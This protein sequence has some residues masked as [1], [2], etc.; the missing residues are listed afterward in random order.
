MN[1][2]TRGLIYGTITFFLVGLVIW[3]GIVYV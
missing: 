3:L 1:D 2:D